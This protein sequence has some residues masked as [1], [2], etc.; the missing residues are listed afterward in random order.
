MTL[1]TH[2][3]ERRTVCVLDMQG[4]KTGCH[5][6]DAGVSPVIMKGH[7]S[8][9]HVVCRVAGDAEDA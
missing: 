9:V 5:V 1:G 7:S 2:K 3:G 4:G 8:V 6:G